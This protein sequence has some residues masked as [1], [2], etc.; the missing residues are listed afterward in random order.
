MP[1]LTYVNAPAGLP[2]E[3]REALTAMFR[4]VVLSPA[5]QQKAEED[6][7]T[8]DALSGEALA[9]ELRRVLAAIRAAQ[10]KARV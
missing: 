10:E 6:G 2:P 3:L 9:E 7:Y 1:L 5:Y 4:E 8:A